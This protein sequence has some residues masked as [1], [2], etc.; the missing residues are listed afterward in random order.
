MG[1]DVG[2][3]GAL[4]EAAEH[5]LQRVGG[6]RFASPGE[7]QRPRL[8]PA[9]ADQVFQ[10]GD[11]RCRVERDD[12]FAA[13]LAHDSQLAGVEIDVGQGEPEHLA[14]AN[15]GRPEQAEDGDVAGLVLDGDAV[16][17]FSAGPIGG[18]GEQAHHV[19]GHDLGEDA[20]VGADGADAAQGV[21]GDRPAGV[22]PPEPDRSHLLVPGAITGG[23]A[24]FAEG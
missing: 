18:G 24:L 3:P 6:H 5:D 22:E 23:H 15:P 4:F 9:L 16:A 21:A 14:R 12:A 2:A 17:L 11:L 13:P 19:L 1:G 8:A 7:Q 20:L 10:E